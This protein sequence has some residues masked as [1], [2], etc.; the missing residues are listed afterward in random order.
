MEEYKWVR[1]DMDLY[2]IKKDSKNIISVK[3]SGSLDIDFYEYAKNFYEAAERVIHYLIDKVD[4][5]YRD[6]WYFPVVYLYRQSLELMLKACIF[7][8]ITE[9]VERKEIVG[10]I[11]HDL[12]QAFNK[13]IEIKGL[14]I[15]DNENAKWLKSF[16]KDISDIDRNSDMFRYPFGNNME[17]LFDKQTHISLVGTHN[18]MNRAFYIIKEIYDKGIL[19]DFQY[20]C[21]KPKLIIEGGNYY[22][23]SVVGNPY[24]QYKFYVYF[25][26]YKEVG[27]FLKK[28]IIND[29]LT[30]LFMPMCYILRNAIE[31]GLKML[32]VE[33]SRFS[34]P[35]SNKI[36]KRK[37][38]S[39]LALW[40]F[41]EDEIKYYAPTEDESTLIIARKYIN[42]FHQLD[43]NSDLFRY[44]C[45]K[46]LDSHFFKEKKM[47]I[48][49]VSSCFEELCN[50]L[51][52]VDSMLGA[53]K[54]L[55]ASIY[56][57]YMDCY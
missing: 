32:I 47:D 4:F 29:K 9:A 15:D 5:S 3:N 11:R 26:S 41:I 25:D 57:E 49:N 55:E 48:E 14:A 2:K 19:S 31:L 24:F 13:L 46:F 17:L 7:Q 52:G 40:N 54:D 35:E 53:M 23:E 50:F 56:A 20:E 33:D 38:H 22:H 21:N 28:I 1:S 6:A 34:F 42:E 12:E 39:L 37:K 16:L 30:N 18:N 27:K 10:L 36:I 8:V 44:P 43:P 51:N 45:N